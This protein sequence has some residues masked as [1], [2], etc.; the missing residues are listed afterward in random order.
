[1]RNTSDPYFKQNSQEPKHFR[2]GE[3]KVMKKSLSLLVAIAMVF[4]MFASV[5]AAAEPELTTQQKFDALKEAGIFSGYPPNGDAGLNREM[6]RAEFSKVIALIAELEQDASAATYSDVPANY[7]AAPFIGAVTADGIM[8]GLGGG[9][10]GPTGKVTIEQVAKI[11]VELAGLEPVEG[12]TVPGTS[13]WATGYVAAAIEAG[14]IPQ[15]ASYKGNALRSLLVEVAYDV[16]GGEVPG[17]ITVK[18]VKVVDDKNIEVTFSDNEVVKKALDTALVAG[19]ATKVSV[20]YKGKTYEVEVK[21]DALKA[22]AAK[23]TGAKKITV[24]FNQPALAA[25]KADLTYEL[26]YGFNTYHVTPTYADD[27]K[28]VV[29]E[30]AYL[31]TGDYTLTVKGSDAISLKVETEKAAKVDITSPALTKA[32]DVSL[33][34]K[35]FNQFGEEMTGSLNITATNLSQTSGNNNLTVNNGKV[36]LSSN[37]IKIGDN[38][39]V[40]AVYPS[41]GLSANKTLKVVNGSIATSIKLGEVA[42]LKDK[43][44]ISISQQGF[45]LPLTLTDANGQ[46]VKLPQGNLPDAPEQFEY[47]GLFFY[48]SDR[49]IITNMTV[50]DK[51]VIK[52]DTLAKS[53]NVTIIV[54]NPAAGVNA[55][56][57]V[58]VAGN[59]EVKE[60]QISHPGKVIVK[61][62]EI[63]IP[64]NAVDNFGAKI[65]PKDFNLEGSKVT[66]SLNNLNPRT[67][68]KGELLLTFPDKGSFTL[69]VFV[70]GVQQ[71]DSLQVTVDDVAKVTGF[72]GL[73]DVETTLEVGAEVKFAKDNIK[74]ID[75]Y[76]RE[77]D[78][79]DNAYLNITSDNSN[80]SV[81]AT[82]LKAN[83]A[84][85][86]KITVKWTD[87]TNASNVQTKEFTFNVVKSD[88]IKTYE[89]KNVGLVYGKAPAGQEDNYAKDIVL[90]GKTSSGTNVALASDKA[91]FVASSDLSVLAIHSVYDYKVVG[92]KAGKA[93]VSAY[94]N[95]KKVAEQEVTVSEDTPAAKTAKFKKDE[96]SVNVGQTITVEMEIKDQY[97]VAITP[98]FS[99][100]TT[101][102]AKATVAGGTLNVTGVAKGYTTL[103]YVSS[104]GVTASTTIVVNN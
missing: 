21:L 59:A 5:A 96:Y 36:N 103:N 91:P 89:I 98:S 12:A 78:V 43:S 99:I 86:S 4:S 100:S 93:T 87:P 27:N 6:T 18:S 46:E 67:N 52:F 90:V 2:G 84:G 22:T 45:V 63:A 11:V 13:A 65:E 83:T 29:L 66:F 31:P 41:A 62:E 40:T 81:T 74:L 55:T 16:A 60:F 101:D 26:K 32:A 68:A 80:V 47:A 97:D 3:K 61:G 42:P 71:K 19:T 102:A 85:S 56:I 49:Q 72:K 1:M 8:N 69:Y 95:S 48:V 64:Y 24:D 54:T 70:N 58:P 77:K 39:F 7:W 28:S 35:L 57:T 75:T 25:D 94:I 33:G 34:A 51:G 92:K 76:G 15:Q 20:E 38:I 9:K 14:L 17:A 37:D 73:K 88:D 10:F 79:T 82:G 44:R 50:D 104:N 30:A 53:G 23:Q